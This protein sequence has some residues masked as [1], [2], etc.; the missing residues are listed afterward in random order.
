MPDFSLRLAP[1]NEQTA[2]QMIRE[3]RQTQLI[4][5]YRQLPEG[6]CHALARAIVAFS[7]LALIE[8]Q[9]VLE[10]EIN[11]LFVR[12]DGVVAVDAVVRLQEKSQMQ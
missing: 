11:P 2:W 12:Q 7:R 5:G 9:P 6:D 8:S 10:A 4:R 3:V 1:V